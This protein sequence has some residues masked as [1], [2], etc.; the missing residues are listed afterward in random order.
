MNTNK[1]NED[2]LKLL[3]GEVVADADKDTIDEVNMLKQTLSYVNEQQHNP[4]ELERLLF[5]LKR[6]KLLISKKPRWQNPVFLSAI[7]ASVMV[8]MIT[9]QYPSV[10]P[11]EDDVPFKIK[12]FIIPQ[13]IKHNNP[14]QQ[15]Q[16]ILAQLQEVNVNASLNDQGD[17][18][19]IDIQL[20]EKTNEISQLLQKFGIMMPKG[21]QLRVDIMKK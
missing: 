3:A 5:R 14:K 16:V 6:E 1:D 4:A 2:W 9:T 21:E 7:A 13:I 11:F 8:I 15:A 17:K 10:V 12:G 19:V 20:T 18:Y